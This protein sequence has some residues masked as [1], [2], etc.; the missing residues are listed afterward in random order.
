MQRGRRAVLRAWACWGGWVALPR[1]ARAQSNPSRGEVVRVDLA[2]ARITVKHS[3]VAN[4][5]M[6]PM[7]IVFGVANPGM[8]EGIEAGQRVR[9]S[10]ERVDGRY[11][12]TSI[13]RLP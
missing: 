13:Q 1:P 7:T 4:L 2:N 9:F 12:L 6:P 8:L 3:G 10:V 11:I 5:D